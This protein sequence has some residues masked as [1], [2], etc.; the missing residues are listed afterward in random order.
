MTQSHGLVDPEDAPQ[1]VWRLKR[2]G[3][4]GVVQVE[5]I[6]AKARAAAG[7]GGPRD[8]KKKAGTGRRRDEHKSKGKPLDP[9]V[10]SD[11]RERGAKGKRAV[12]KAAKKGKKG[13]GPKTAGRGK[14]AGGTKKR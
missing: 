4:G 13:K 10:R 12:A 8:K 11:Q 5:K 3:R 6:Y 7:Q 14:T 1:A 9:R 2:R